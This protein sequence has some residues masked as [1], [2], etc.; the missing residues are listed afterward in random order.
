MNHSKYIISSILASVFLVSQVFA[1]DTAPT[2]S[3][4]PTT[5]A[6]ATLSPTPPTPPTTGANLNVPGAPKLVTQTP[7]SVTLEWVGVPAAKSYIVKYSKT[8]VSEAF[9]AGKTNATYDME[10][11]QV[12]STGTT[13]KDLK[14]GTVYYFAVV[15]LDA[16][17]NESMTNSEELAVTLAPATGATAS[18]AVASTTSEFKLIG[19][20]VVD[21]M[22]LMIDFNAPLSTDPVSVKLVKSSNA[23]ATA[24]KSIVPGK[25]PAQAVITLATPLDAASSYSL[26]VISAKDSKGSSI[27]QGLN[28]VKEFATSSNLVKTAATTVLPTV[29]AM[30]TASGVTLSGSTLSGAVANTEAS[31]ALNAAPELPATGTQETLLLVL[32]AIIAFAIVLFARARRA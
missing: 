15:A 25:T 1:A 4:A 6:T 26:V 11:D 3:P 5:P 17:N 24:I 10:S 16:T 23:A 13:I 7:T 27:S 18:G 12:T 32:A 14:A 29:G 31:G 30:A 8:S 22:T 9:K 28:A 21:A 2:A 19:V 20:S